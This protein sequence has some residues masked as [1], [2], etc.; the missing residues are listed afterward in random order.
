MTLSDR[1]AQ[2]LETKTDAGLRAD[3]MHMLQMNAQ[4]TRETYE[5][6]MFHGGTF[7]FEEVAALAAAYVREI[8]KDQPRVYKRVMTDNITVKEHLG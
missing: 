5:S 1:V 3:A 8:T 7:T 4:L 2:L 6:S